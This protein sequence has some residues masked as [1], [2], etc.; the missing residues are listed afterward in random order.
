MLRADASAFGAIACARRYG[1]RP[2]T[3]KEE[4]HVK[5][6]LLLVVLS[7]VALCG[8]SQHYPPADSKIQSATAQFN[9]PP[10]DMLQKVKQIVTAPPLSL[11]IEQEEQGTILTTP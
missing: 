9:V 7:V 4:T 3:S 2:L 8:C 1:Y 10:K 5:D 11:G 6:S